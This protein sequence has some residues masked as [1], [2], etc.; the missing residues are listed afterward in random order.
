MFQAGPHFMSRLKRGGVSCQNI[1]TV[2]RTSDPS[3]AKRQIANFSKLTSKGQFRLIPMCLL[4]SIKGTAVGGG[5]GNLRNQTES[6]KWSEVADQKYI[7][8]IFE[9]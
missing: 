5:E 1:I 8:Q 7:F 3:R 2:G 6:E 4:L 9:S